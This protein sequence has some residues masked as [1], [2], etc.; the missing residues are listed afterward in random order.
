MA[1]SNDESI[2]Q[3]YFKGCINL[4]LLA[5]I[6]AIGAAVCFVALNRVEIAREKVRNIDI[7]SLHGDEWTVHFRSCGEL[8]AA[9]QIGYIEKRVGSTL[10]AGY[11]R[12]DQFF[13]KFR[14]DSKFKAAL[15]GKLSGQIADSDIEAGKKRW[16]DWWT[17]KH[18]KTL[19]YNGERGSVYLDENQPDIA[20]MQGTPF[21]GW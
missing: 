9:E 11:G 6:G 5:F 1:F 12:Y 4:L 16:P 15:D 7:A 18:K 19:E 8:L 17:A 20:F 21:Y 14:M 10:L 2:F 13:Y 3:R